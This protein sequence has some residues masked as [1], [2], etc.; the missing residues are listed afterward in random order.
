MTELERFAPFALTTLL[1]ELT[2]GPN[3]GYLA[4][5]SARYGRTAGLWVVA[6]VAAG[7][8]IDLI[9]TLTGISA[10]LIAQPLIYQA[11][12][13]AGVAVMVW[14]AIEA[15]RSSAGGSGEAPAAEAPRQLLARG[16]V[17]NVL[18]AKAIL[19][20]VTVLP[21]FLDPGRQDLAWQAVIVGVLY[22]TIATGVHVAIVL[23][24]SLPIFVRLN[25]RNS[26]GA[27]R[28]YAVSLLLVAAWLAYATASPTV[29]FG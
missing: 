26:L 15:L 18:N 23:L 24:S 13:W 25:R 27:A 19:F 12:R 29:H 8:T 20:M 1:V 3:M 17:T 6:G 9:A 28:A 16:L 11:V 2:P 4:A 14:L 21:T 7:L 5:V 10:A 22:L